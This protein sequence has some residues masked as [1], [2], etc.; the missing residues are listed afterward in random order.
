M[1]IT[2]KPYP[3][4]DGW[5]NPSEIW[6]NHKSLDQ[7]IDGY[8]TLNVAGRETV[9]YSVSQAG[10]LAGRDGTVIYSRSISPRVLTVTYEMKHKTTDEYHIAYAK[11]SELLHTDVDGDVQISFGDDPFMYKGQVTGKSSPEPGRLVQ[12]GTFEITCQDPFRYQQEYTWVEKGRIILDEKAGTHRTNPEI[13]V[14]VGTATHRIIIRNVTTGKRIIFED[15][16]LV[17]EELSIRI[18]PRPSAN[19][20][21]VNAMTSLAYANS[22][23]GEFKVM[24]GDEL[25][26]EPDTSWLTIKMKGASL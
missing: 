9:G 10:D 13:S 5:I 22:D 2:T 6:I 15:D 17:D 24:E 11:L 26:V 12:I 21:G 18:Y 16:F 23:F 4:D 20:D 1:Y 7:E 25:T 19:L 14:R 8:K 3:Y